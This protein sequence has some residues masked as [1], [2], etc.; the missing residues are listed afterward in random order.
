MALDKLNLGAVVC[1]ITQ[2]DPGL[3]LSSALHQKAQETIYVS[4]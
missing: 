2:E 1:A 4:T 3:S